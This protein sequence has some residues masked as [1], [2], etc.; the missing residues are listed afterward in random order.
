MSQLVSSGCVNG[1]DGIGWNGVRWDG[2]DMGG[3]I[4]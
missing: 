4:N 3:I 1:W 2:A